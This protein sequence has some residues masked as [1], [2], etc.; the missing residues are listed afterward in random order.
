MNARLT[1]TAATAVVLA[2]VSLY[3]LFQGGAWF[4]AGVGAVIATALVGM[5]AR[6]PPLYAAVAAAVLALTASCPLLTSAGWP[7]KAL[8]AVIIIITA[9]S[10]ARIRLLQVLGSVLTY[11]ASLLIY[12]NVAFAAR[13]SVAG[14]VPTATSVRCLWLLAARA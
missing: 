13:L 8:G 10:P 3:P 7:G 5:L 14:T 1:L 2:S 6:L 9:A 11:A 12:L 4:W